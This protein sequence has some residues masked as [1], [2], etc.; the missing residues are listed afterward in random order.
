MQIR[1]M[2]STDAPRVAMLHIEGISTGFI[3]SLG[4]G[5]VTSLY[6]AIS[7]SKSSFGYVA[8]QEDEVIGFVAFSKNLSGLYKEI[9]KK[10]FIRFGFLLAGKM[11]SFKNIKK[12]AQNVL[13]PSKM[14]KLHLPQAELLSIVVSSKGR[15]KGIARELVIRGLE[16]CRSAG[17]DEVKVLVAKDNDAA[18]SLYQ[19]CNF[20]FFAELDSHGVASNIYVAKPGSNEG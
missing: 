15:G 3:A 1:P 20:E 11:L 8:E 5:F 19:K 6:R 17:I 9:L 13:Y 18:N 12:V 16:N 4:A 7:E 10:N 14:K 2:E